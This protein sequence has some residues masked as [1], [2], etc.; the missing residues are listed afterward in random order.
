[1]NAQSRTLQPAHWSRPRGYANGIAAQG[2]H[3]AVAGQIGWNAREQ[4]ETDDLV[5]QVRQAILNVLA[6]LAEAGGR[7]EHIVRM[8]WYLLDKREYL[9][10]VR[11]IGAVY[12][13]LM[14]PPGGNVH[15][16]AMS[17]VQIV[18]LMEDR[19][20]VEIECTAVI[21]P[22]EQRDGP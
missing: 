2:T 8:T 4:F 5:G 19:A 6:V 9:A 1:M 11:E 12:R 7:P 10:R 20:K 17:A 14:T 21:P 16:P 22:I 15:Y 13:E 18:A 3:V